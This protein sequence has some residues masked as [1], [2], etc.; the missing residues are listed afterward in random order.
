[1]YMYL[2]TPIPTYTGVLYSCELAGFSSVRLT[3]GPNVKS[4]PEMILKKLVKLMDHA[5][6]DL[7]NLEY[8]VHAMNGNG[9][10]V[11]LQKLERKNL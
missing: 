10:Y 7:T 8:V 9:S 6:N 4:P 11:N 3:V 2:C 1:M 5:C